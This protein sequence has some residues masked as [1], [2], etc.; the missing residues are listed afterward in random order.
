MTDKM[1]IRD[2]LKPVIGVQL[3]TGPLVGTLT[4]ALTSLVDTH[5]VPKRE[6]VEVCLL[7]TSRC[8]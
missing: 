3:N 2:R 6:Q 1:C 7:Y 8:V 5:V 4:Q